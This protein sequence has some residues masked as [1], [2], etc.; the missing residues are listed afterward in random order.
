[1]KLTYSVLKDNDV[2]IL[3]DFTCEPFQ[4]LVN[5]KDLFKTILSKNTD[6]KMQLDGYDI[7]LH[8]NEVIF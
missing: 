7:V 8:C 6:V 5:I 4:N 3:T 1:M 2:L